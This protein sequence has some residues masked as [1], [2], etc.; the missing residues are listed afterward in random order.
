MPRFLGLFRTNMD[1]LNEQQRINAAAM[2]TV[3]QQMVGQ[4]ATSSTKITPLETTDAVAWI[5]FRSEFTK[6]LPLMNWT[7]DQ[8]KQQ[9][10]FLCKKE[11]GQVV[12][13]VPLHLDEADYTIEQ[14]L[15]AFEAKFLST[16]ATAAAVQE[17]QSARQRADQSITAWHSYLHSLH[18]RAFP[19]IN[20]DVRNADQMLANYFKA[21]IFDPTLRAAA[22]TCVTE[23]Y[24]ALL[25]A[26]Q[27]ISSTVQMIKRIPGGQSLNALGVASTSQ[28]NPDSMIAAVGSMHGYR[29]TRETRCHACEQPGHF[30]RDC[31]IG[32]RAIR[33]YQKSSPRK[34]R[35]QQSS[36]ATPRRTPGNSTYSS[37]AK[38]SPG[39]F[40]PNR[41][42]P[43]KS[44]G[45]VGNS[46]KIQ[47]TR[48]SG[49][50]STPHYRP[51]LNAMGDG[52]NQEYEGEGSE[53]H[54]EHEYVDVLSHEEN[55]ED[56]GNGDGPC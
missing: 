29:E 54:E 55:G 39:K 36:P 8:Q 47:K 7:L 18:R 49:N 43:N 6:G 45:R 42:S 52:E 56:E 38:G 51:G 24:D 32:Q 35:S 31:P 15:D 11:A 41:N 48:W 14:L 46:G 13:N 9:L 27:Q 22:A 17:Y 34:P 50:R 4:R 25:P 40:T 12:Q 30:W 23:T 26:I 3:I 1:Q 10:L 21:G 5:E 37:P 20:A 28:E 33:M 2:A 16:A 53:M 19:A 44:G